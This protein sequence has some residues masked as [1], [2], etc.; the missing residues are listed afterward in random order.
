MPRSTFELSLWGFGLGLTGLLYG[1]ASGY[2]W[3]SRG[4]LNTSQRRPHLEQTLAPAVDSAYASTFPST[5]ASA[6]ASATVSTSYFPFA[7]TSASASNPAVFAAAFPASSSSSSA[8]VFA[9]AL[10]T[11]FCFARSVTFLNG[12]RLKVVAFRFPLAYPIGLKVC[13]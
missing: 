6:C 1:L 2:T 10:C 7:S 3:P 5:A 4:P 9:F 12:L 11:P 8:F 13:Q